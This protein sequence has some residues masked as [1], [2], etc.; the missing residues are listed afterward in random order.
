MNS[1]DA[2]MA[3]HKSGELQKLCRT[4][5]PPRYADDLIQEVLLALLEKPA[6]KILEMHAAGYFKWYVVR[7]ACN[8]YSSKHSGFHKVYRHFDL[9]DHGITINLDI[10]KVDLEINTI[11]NLQQPEEEYCI[12][13]D[14]REQQRIDRCNQAYQK[15]STGKDYPY[16]QKLLD[17]YLKVGNVSKISRETGIPYRTLLHQLKAIIQRIKDETDG[18]ATY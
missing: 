8:M 12:E 17:L 13:T 5:A 9:I 14:Q 15:L 11:D 4:V 2:I 7:M 16:E 3:L 10:G 18:T 1:N 6:A